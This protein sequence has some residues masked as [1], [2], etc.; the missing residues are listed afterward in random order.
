MI[1]ELP[2]NIVEYVKSLDNAYLH[3]VYESH[4]TNGGYGHLLFRRV[5]ITRATRQCIRCGYDE[6]KHPE[7]WD[8]CQRHTYSEP[9]FVPIFYW[10]EWDGNG[11]NRKPLEQTF[12]EW[13]KTQNQ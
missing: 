12:E 5:F 3:D 10:S 13:E 6:I 4:S 2:D 8:K 7:L 11:I 9:I 1:C